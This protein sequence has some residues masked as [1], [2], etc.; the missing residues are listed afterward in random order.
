MASTEARIEGRAALGRHHELVAE[1]EALVRLYPARAPPR[2]AD[3]GHVPLPGR[4]AGAL[5]AYRAARKSWSTSWGSSPA[6]ASS[7]WSRPSWPRT[8][9]STCWSRTLGRPRAPTTTTATPTG[10]G[11]SAEGG[12]VE[13]KLVSVLF[14]V[15]EPLGEAGER[16]PEDACLL[17]PHLDRIE[18]EIESFGGT[19]E[20]IID[21]HHH[22]HLQGPQTREDD[23]EQAVRAMAIRD[24]LAGAGSGVEL[25]VAV[26]TGGPGHRRHAG[27]GR[28]PVATCARL[29]QAAPSG[30]CWCR[31]RPAG[32]PSG[33]SATARPADLLC[34]ALKS[35]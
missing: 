10:N 32:P 35:R 18:A 11:T 4:Q 26:T 13:R 22:G 17:D 23:P 25:R 30:P 1:L 28:R 15:D 9:P 8:R 5:A 33:R 27:R 16:D 6:S 14:A 7:G 3:A 34:R 2:P 24:S 29:Q 12:T 20:H 21:G 19:V 31:R